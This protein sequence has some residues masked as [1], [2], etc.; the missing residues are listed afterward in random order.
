MTGGGRPPAQWGTATGGW[1]VPKITMEIGRPRHPGVTKLA[2]KF[3]GV[4]Q[5]GHKILHYRSPAIS[6]CP[7][8]RK[9]EA[10]QSRKNLPNR[11]KRGFRL[12][13][14]FMANKG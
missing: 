2:N 13:H 3:G 10:K 11:H 6:K 5:F 14:S 1:I 7:N 8:S 4:L 12:P 9:T